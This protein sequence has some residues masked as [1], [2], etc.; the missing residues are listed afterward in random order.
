M[1]TRTL[2]LNVLRAEARPMT[3]ADLGKRVG[4]TPQLARV[5]VKKLCADGLVEAA[6]VRPMG[7]NGKHAQTFQARG[8]AWKP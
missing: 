2:I 5:H 1:N 3:L 8:E 7:A 6:G 4:I